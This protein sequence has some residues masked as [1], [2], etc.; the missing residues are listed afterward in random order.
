MTPNPS[1][2]CALKVSLQPVSANRLLLALPR[3]EYAAVSEHLRHV[4]VHAGDLLQAANTSI[5]YIW[6]PNDC[7]ISIRAEI[8]GI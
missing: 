3:S 8:M 7:L 6:F 4:E 1:T 5:R 2:E